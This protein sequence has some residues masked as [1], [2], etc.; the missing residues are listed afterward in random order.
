MSAMSEIDAELR[1]IGA[2][3][4]EQAAYERYVD[5]LGV[6]EAEVWA[7]I[8]GGYE[9][10]KEE[11]SVPVVRGWRIPVLGVWVTWGCSR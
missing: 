11:L 1:V 7:S 3:Y 10:T 5:Y 8:W 9:A 2:A 4:G 6:P